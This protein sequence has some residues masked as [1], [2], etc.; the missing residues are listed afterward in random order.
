MRR[1]AFAAL[2][3]TLITAPAKADRA[4]IVGIDVYQESALSFQ[5]PN[6]SFN[7][8]ERMRKLLTG[9]L[10]YKDSEI[11]ILRNEQATRAA[12]LEGLKEWLGETKPGERAFFYFVGHGHFQPDLNG[13]EEDKLDEALVP[14]D[15]VIKRTETSASVENMVV[16]DEIG[17]A[18][19]ELKGRQITAVLDSCHSGT[20]TRAIGTGPN[21]ASR[22]PQLQQ[23]T[24][25]ITGDVSAQRQKQSGR[26]ADPVSAEVGLVTWTAVSPSQLAL[27]DEDA[28]PNYRGLFTSAFAD[29][30]EKGLA[31]K[32]ANGVI[33]NQELLDFVRSRAEDYCTRRPERCEMGV[34]PMMEG[35]GAATRAAA[36]NPVLIAGNAAA[37][38]GGEAAK[39]KVAEA[40]ADPQAAQEKIDPELLKVALDAAGEAPKAE[41]VNAEAI[42]TAVAGSD[43]SGDAAA[44]EAAVNTALAS[45]KETAEAA[46][47]KD[48]ALNKGKVTPEKIMDMLG[49]SL[50]SDVQI[51]QIP[52]SPIKLGTKNIRFRVTS[53][54]DGFLIL[55]SVSDE[56]EVVQLFPTIHSDKNNKNGKILANSPI[57]VP[58]KSYG[59]RFDATSVTSGTVMALVAVDPLNLS[60]EFV[61]R[62]IEVIPQD[63]VNDKVLPEL[64]ESLATPAAKETP[65]E[66]TKPVGRGVA[67]VRYEITE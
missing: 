60:R 1:L 13:D 59:I 35:I 28:A 47:P 22:T 7:D 9:V 49:A 48:G 42:A 10:G 19:E 34:T 12:I 26:S 8:S 17:A 4:L 21:K 11:R 67:T 40:V 29:G 24:R 58:D 45:A 65:T 30:I 64:A 18:L 33:S 53:P 36:P 66:N 32:N 43:T 25:S 39:E 50:V 5:L 16:D 55:L 54:K 31:D 63:T 46:V 52:P 14:F 37:A 27:I 3:A 2:L 41:G 62:K 44:V 6:A 15:A 57:T 56:G 38:A 51:E 20:V 61:S 23:L